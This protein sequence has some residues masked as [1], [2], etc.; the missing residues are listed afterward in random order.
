MV[1]EEG[2]V[3]GYHTK[4]TCIGYFLSIGIIYILEGVNGSFFLGGGCTIYIYRHVRL[5]QGGGSI[6]LKGRECHD[7]P[8]YPLPAL[9]PLRLL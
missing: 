5:L 1:L 2:I 3:E 6:Q 8:N 4:G 9:P 7:F